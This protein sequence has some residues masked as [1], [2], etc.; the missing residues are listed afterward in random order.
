VA[1][2]RPH[3]KNVPGRK[4]DLLTDAEWVSDVVA[5]GM[6]RPSFVAPPEIRELLE[7][8]RYRKTQIDARA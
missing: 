4:T 7:L 3:V 6:V 8:T 1:L 5:L 2:R